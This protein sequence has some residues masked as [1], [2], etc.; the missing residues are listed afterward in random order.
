M[1]KKESITVLVADDDRE[2][3][4]IIED[5]LKK[6][7]YQTVHAYNGEEAVALVRQKRIQLVIMDVMMPKSNG[8]MAT[9]E[10][11]RIANVPI[12]MLS[13]KSEE[14]DRVIGLTMGADDYL[15]KPFFKQELL[16]RVH[17]LLRRYLKLGSAADTGT[18]GV[19]VYYD[20]ILDKE[21]K[22]LFVRGEEI[23]L[24]ATEYK[25]MELLLARPGKAF[26]AEEIYERIWNQESYSIENTVMIHVNR[27]R[28][29]IEINPK[30]PEY[31]KVVWGIGYK[32]E[33]E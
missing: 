15:V 7:G 31:L 27:L 5:A 13:A 9:M 23:H 22:K 11:R 1:D 12:L 19:I 33:K 14:S 16:A 24:T 2:I 32:I 21:A 29:K 20:L 17:S 6:E 3:V 25:I 18:E 26:A 8:L 4:S 28:K 10:I 30:K